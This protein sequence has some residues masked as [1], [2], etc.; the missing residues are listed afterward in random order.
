MTRP[1]R[2]VSLAALA[3]AT[4]ACGPEPAA[5]PASATARAAF[6]TAAAGETSGRH[7]VS[8]TSAGAAPAGFV[9]AVARLG[10][11]VELADEALGFVAVSGLSPAAAGRLAQ[12]RG[13]LA[14]EEEPVLL[15]A[16]A[17][18]VEAVE[19]EGVSADAGAIAAN[20][21]A[22]FFYTRGFQ[23]NM[24]AIG[25]DRLWAAGIF[26]APSTRIA[27]LDTGLD[28]T[29]VDLAGRVDLGRSTDL[30]GEAD[31]IAKYVGAG[32]HPI[33]DLNGHGTHVGSTAAS[34]GLVV[35]GVATGV[36]LVGVKVCTMRGLCPVGAV[37]S[38]MRYAA[39][40][41]ARVA[42]MSLGGSFGK[43]GTKGLV[44]LINRTINHASR[45][46]TLLVVSAGNSSTDL[47]HDGDGFKAYCSASSV[48]CVSA[49]GPTGL[50][51]TGP[52]VNPDAFALYSNFGRSAV[53]LAAPGG[54]YILDAAG[55]PV[56]L[57]PVWAACSRTT[58][59]YASS[60]PTP[61][62]PVTGRSCNTGTFIA[63][64]IGTSMA[65]PHASG[66]AALLS[67]RLGSPAQVKAALLQ[68]A[69]DLGEPGTDPYYGK[70][71]LDAAAALLGS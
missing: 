60:S 45:K 68:G 58:L 13:V 9:D 66:V 16:P 50:A 8:F 12:S 21:A 5:P 24:K 42:N 19:A 57:A 47:D 53:D 61:T 2:L 32:R 41:G 70:G 34:N 1:S 28:Y 44:A 14:V 27:I 4:A 20:P 43:A 3:L 38:G 37:L 22:A 11:R 51:A 10:G 33:S 36:S 67:E 55:Q 46:G 56:S 52:F 31:S 18:S 29:Y 49:T 65:A 15:A 35:G 30:V 39:D 17:A 40:V 23:W 25:A 59:R 54:N 48:L 6:L 69:A 26:G 64:F 63:G 7:L 71:R 62:T